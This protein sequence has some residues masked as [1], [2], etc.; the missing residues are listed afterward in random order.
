MHRTA[1]IDTLSRSMFESVITMGLLAKRLINDDT[2]RY[3]NFQFIEHYKKHIHLEKLGLS[4]L[5]GISSS[6]YKLVTKKRNEYFAKWGKNT[7][8]WTGNNLL[9]NVKLIDRSYTSTCNENRFYEYMYC[10]VYRHGSQTVHSSYAGIAHLLSNEE[11]SDTWKPDIAHLIF[12]SFH[13]ILVFS[14]SIRFMGHF[15]QKTEAEEFYNK[16]ADDIISG[17]EKDFKK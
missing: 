11:D 6:E 12:S 16:I 1:D 17:Y 14:S 15:L 13:S 5:S 3:Y 8:T 4:H 10:Q 9:E 7:P 2:E